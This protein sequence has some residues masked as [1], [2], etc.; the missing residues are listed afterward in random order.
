MMLKSMEKPPKNLECSYRNFRMAKARSWVISW[1][2][3]TWQIIPAE[4]SLYWLVVDIFRFMTFERIGLT[5][6]YCYDP[7]YGLRRHFVIKE[8]SEVDEICKKEFPLLDELDTLVAEFEEKYTEMNVS[9]H[10]FLSGYWNVRMEEVTN[11]HLSLD[12]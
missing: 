7:G 4:S 6:T 8:G 5:H 11:K 3:G 2:L 12:N 1:I 9:V 10:E